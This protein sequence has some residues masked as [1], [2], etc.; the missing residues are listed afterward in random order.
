MTITTASPFIRAKKNQTVQQLK[1]S[2]LS[3]MMLLA[4]SGAM[5]AEAP[6]A[7]AKKTE[8]SSKLNT[9]KVNADAE[10]AEFKADKVSSDKFTQPLVDT[11]Q[12]IV[13]VKKELFQQQ[14]ATNLSETLRNTPGITMLLGENGNTATGDS[15]FMRGFDTQGSI[16]VDGIRDLGS[17]SRDT[18]NTEQVEIVKGP[19]GVDNGR[20]AA[21][22]YIN[23]SS[24]K[25]SLEDAITGNVT[26]G[27]ADYKRST[28]DVNK[29]L[30][31]T[32]ALRVNVLGQDAG[33][34]GRDT[35]ENKSLGLATSLGLG[36]GTDTRTYV[37]F[38]HLQQRAI[39]DGGISTIGLDGYYSSALIALFPA[40]IPDLKVDTD[41]FYGHSGDYNDV[42]ATMATVRI[43]QD[44]AA[45][46]TLRNTSRY[47][48]STQNMVLTGV[49]AVSA[50]AATA[51]NLDTWRVALNRQGRDQSNQVLT[52]QTNLS[53][54]F[55]AAGV[56]HDIAS[57][58][59]FIY[60][61]QFSDTLGLPYVSATSATQVTQ[62]TGKLYNFDSS[63]V[64]YQPVVK[65]GAKT[66]GE[67]TTS[68]LYVLDT[69]SLNDQWQVSAGLRAERFYTKTDQIVRQAAVTAPAPQ[70]TPIGTYVGRDA[71]LADNLISW[72]LGG[73]YKPAENGSI[74]LSYATSQLPP[75]GANFT[76]NTDP[77][78]TANA[79]T[80]NID[81]QKGTNQ[82]LGTKW[83]I[84][85]NKLA[86]TAALFKS[87]NENEIAT[88]TDGSSLAIGEREVKGL[89]LGVAGIVMQNW[90]ISAGF[91]YM[92]PTI[93]HGN[94]RVDDPTTTANEAASN[95]DGG[96]IQW[97]PKYTFTLWNSYAFKNGLT[98]GGG[99]RYIDSVAS[100]SLTNTTAQ[101]TRSILNIPEYWVVDAM[102]SYAVSKNV[103]VQLNI[104]N[105]ADEEYIGSLNNSGARYYPG[106]P[107]SARLGANF[108]F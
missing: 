20:G 57:G 106:A 16:F 70:T 90:Q 94:N 11:P 26:L 14:A 8:A 25:A 34:D 97:S 107:R 42:D 86:L 93:N 40:G 92:D 6:K 18:F 73:V 98:L 101:S 48:R 82:E 37:N 78:S 65:T 7:E 96:V 77:S 17:I 79:N 45:G 80:P 62:V 41:T 5:A 39:P 95:T 29:S 31:E 55:D 64:A 108:T 23:L 19:A 59:E 66:D 89:E 10:V 87:T 105:L 71:E 91:A 22:G 63:A 81:P 4:A 56:K 60:E 13:V 51:T 3:S 83:N 44:L 47:G 33:V 53:A 84:N 32:S 12:T 46:V 15:I 24:K 74:Y 72:K 85:G 75:G 2:A 76:L 104:M 100:S 99:A 88:N 52:N 28:L 38:Y 102:A 21:S 67:T 36:L 54:S 49:N 69:I 30:T 50:P 103:T 27:T 43:E 1:V 35:V 58:L 68:A 9:V 61:S